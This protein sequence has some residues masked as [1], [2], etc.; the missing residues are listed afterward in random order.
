MHRSSHALSQVE[1]NYSPFNVTKC[2]VEISHENY[3][4]KTHKKLTLFVYTMLFTT[5]CNDYSKISREIK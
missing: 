1:S 5:I 3:Y 2:T 4:G